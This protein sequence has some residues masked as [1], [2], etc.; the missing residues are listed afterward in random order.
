MRIFINI[1]F[2]VVLF[3]LDIVGVMAGP[4]PPVPSPRKKGG[5]PPPNPGL[6]IDQDLVILLIIAVLFGVYVIYK[7]QL[8][9]KTPV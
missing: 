4:N 7:H 8:K 9:Q 1:F 5:G 2:V 6:P 3:L